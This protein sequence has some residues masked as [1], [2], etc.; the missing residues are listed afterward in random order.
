[1]KNYDDSLRHHNKC[2]H[3]NGVGFGEDE[4]GEDEWE[5]ADVGYFE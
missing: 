2:G 5:C 1:M 4:E 3:E